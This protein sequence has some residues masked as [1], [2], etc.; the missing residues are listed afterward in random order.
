M[1]LTLWSVA[2]STVSRESGKLS[3]RIDML[4]T[5]TEVSGLLLEGVLRHGRG[6]RCG[7]LGSTCGEV[8]SPRILGLGV[9]SGPCR[10]AP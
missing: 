4:S 7:Y 9:G 8:R 2:A 1:D 6:L 3:G 10:S 5:R